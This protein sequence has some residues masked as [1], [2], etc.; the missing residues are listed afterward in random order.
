VPANDSTCSTPSMCL[1]VSSFEATLYFPNFLGVQQFSFC[2][3]KRNFF[4]SLTMLNFPYCHNLPRFQL[5]HVNTVYWTKICGLQLCWVIWKYRGLP[6]LCFCL[7]NC[8]SHLNNY[9]DNWCENTL[10]V[11]QPSNN[12]TL[13]K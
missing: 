5:L 9:C 7:L 2:Y 13:N 12:R 3:L 1:M 6:V 10:Y 4:C 11:H 8:F